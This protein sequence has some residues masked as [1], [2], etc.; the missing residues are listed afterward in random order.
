MFQILY[1]LNKRFY[2]AL[3]RVRAF[4]CSLAQVRL[5]KVVEE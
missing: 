2:K 4:V 3:L 5:K 1:R